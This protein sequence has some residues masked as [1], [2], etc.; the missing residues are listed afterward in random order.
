[1]ASR[2]ILNANPL[3]SLVANVEHLPLADKDF[4]IVDT[5]TDS[6]LLEVHCWSHDKFIDQVDDIHLWDSN[7]PKYPFPQT[8][9]CPELI[10]LRQINYFPNERDI[11]TPT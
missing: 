9:Q 11:V 4:K 8:Y 3:Q 5:M 2:S 7:L 10:R 6:N 1:M